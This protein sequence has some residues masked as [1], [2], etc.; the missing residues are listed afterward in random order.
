MV[1]LKNTIKKERSMKKLLLPLVTLVLVVA[2]SSSNNEELSVAREGSPPNQVVEYVWHY[3]DANFSEENLNML[4]D[5]WNNSFF[6][7]LSFFIVFFKH[8]MI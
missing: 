4:I 8:T 6:I 7:F 3:K 2:C 5:K 1:C